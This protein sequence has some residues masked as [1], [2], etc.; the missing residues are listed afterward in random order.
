M[1]PLLTASHLSYHSI[2]DDV[3]LSLAP[4]ELVTLI[5]PNGAGKTT[6]LRLILGLLKPT[7]GTC[8]FRPNIRIGYM[9]QRLSLDKSLPLSVLD[10]LDL[11][12]YKH[13]VL[14]PIAALERVSAR[15]LK[16]QSM[17]VL[18]GG[19]WQ[20]V[21]LARA[22]IGSPHIL[23]LDEPV[24]GVDVQGQ[25]DF[26]ALIHDLKRTLKA[27]ILLVS[28][29]LHFVHSASDRVICLHRHICCEGKP[30]D[31]QQDQSYQ[32][33][34]GIIPS[35]ETHKPYAHVHDHTHHGCA[36]DKT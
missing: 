30:A 32:K 35:F 22:I 28:H 27:A 8:V 15:H 29:D 24:Q 3:S 21:L 16:N 31:V 36:E 20:R 18:S 17:H 6:L 11:T 34:I 26:Y 10:F 13:R 19:E 1:T 14:S 5:G 33:L 12:G 2:I 9:P 23:F 7:S 4:Q 25:V